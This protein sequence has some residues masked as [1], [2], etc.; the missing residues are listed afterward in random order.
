MSLYQI[1]MATCLFLFSDLWWQNLNQ[2]ASLH[3]LLTKGLFFGGLI[4]N[5]ITKKKN[6]AQGKLCIK[7]LS[8]TY[9]KH[10]NKLLS[11]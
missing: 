7:W 6:S 11:E 5:I 3:I 4:I 2:N 10:Y 8:D 9:N 1:L